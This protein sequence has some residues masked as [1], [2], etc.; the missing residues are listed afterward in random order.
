MTTHFA[1]LIGNGVTIDNNGQRNDGLPEDRSLP[2]A[3]SDAKA[4]KAFL[5]AV[6]KP[7]D[8]IMLTASRAPQSSLFS[9][10]MEAPEL[11]PTRKNVLAALKRVAANCAAGDQ[12]Y[13]HFSG[14]GTRL[15][16]PDHYGR[17]W[18]SVALVLYTDLPEGLEYLYS[19][20]L[21]KYLV[22][23][24]EKG[25][26]VTLVLD[27]CFSG[28]VM[29]TQTHLGNLVRFLEYKNADTHNFMEAMPP[30]TYVDR[31]RG[32]SI[33]FNRHLALNPESY[34]ILTACGFDEVAWE[35]RL[36]D[37]T[38]MGAMTRFF[39][40][41]LTALREAGTRVSNQSLHQ[42]L[43]TRIHAQITHQTPMLYGRGSSSFF[44][45]LLCNDGVQFIP[46]YRNYNDNRIILAA[47]QTH[48]VQLG[49]TYAAYRFIAS[50]Q[51]AKVKN[52]PHICLR[53]EFLQCLT[54]YM[55]TTD[56]DEDD[57]IRRGSSWKAR[58]ISCAP[59]QR[60][61]IRL[62]PSIPIEQQQQLL[63]KADGNY[64]FVFSVNAKSELPALFQVSA[65]EKCSYQ[66]E[67][68]LSDQV[69][70]TPHLPFNSEG[71]QEALITTL[72]HLVAYKMFESLENRHPDPEF[73]TSFNCQALYQPENDDT[74]F[75]SITP[76]PDRFFNTSE[77][78]LFQ[79]RL[80]NTGKTPLYMAA[81]KLGSSW[82]I[83]N[84]LASVGEG[85]VLP[86]L[87]RGTGESGDTGEEELYFRMSLS[88]DFVEAGLLQ[89]WDIL[90]IFIINSPTSFPSVVL[91]PISEAFR[92]SLDGLQ[93]VLDKFFN[94]F[95]PSRDDGV[96]WAVRD[97]YVRTSRQDAISSP[98]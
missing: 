94:R 46:L 13:I 98:S 47:G 16:V 41:S 15:P 23:I 18:E 87:P 51:E 2:G 66:I 86:I 40:E 4:V 38:R 82:S 75:E 30:K 49:D 71:S 90:K 10:P 93:S 22:M 61:H 12:V 96:K 39:L 24:T 65:T 83:N 64:R 31:H 33:G 78:R 29:R 81:F 88:P 44:D 34:T 43:C 32:A 19:E 97:F 8:I 79:I 80:T 37:G 6:S 54:A 67:D 63:S 28:S 85:D 3:A 14:H 77:G 5:L 58:L 11:L 76:G 52:E 50:E 55:S 91:P 7:V 74:L 95:L 25:S 53:V 68:T 21:H 42:A 70:N 84:L 92:G 48:G 26:Y 9:S 35:C 72:N 20:T 17:S 59:S 36:N 56:P 69:T 57:Q 1:I 27:C 60:V 62:M 73:E 89:G 45:D